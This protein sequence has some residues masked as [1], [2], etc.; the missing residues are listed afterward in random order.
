MINKEQLYEIQDEY[1]ELAFD[2]ESMLSMVKQYEEN[3]LDRE[4]NE[5]QDTIR[6]IKIVA[7]SIEGKITKL[8]SK[9]DGIMLEEE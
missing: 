6:V 8:N 7:E 5:F 3:Y 4:K 1:V 9:F 2:I